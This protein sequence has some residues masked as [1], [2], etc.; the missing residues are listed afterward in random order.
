MTRDAL[1]KGRFVVLRLQSVLVGLLLLSS[2]VQAQDDLRVEI[3]SNESNARKRFEWFYSQRA[4]P[5][6]TVEQ[7]YLHRALEALQ[8]YPVERTTQLAWENIGPQPGTYFNYGNIGGRVPALAVHPTNSSIVYIGPADGGVWKTT[9]SGTTWTPLTDFLASLAS[10]SLAIDKNNP[11]TIYWGTGEPYYS[12]DAYGGAGVFRSTDGGASWTSAGLSAEKRIPRLAIDPNNS[13]RLFAATWG[14]IYRTTNS[15]GSWTKTLNLGYGYEVVIHPTNSSILY[16]GI[17]DNTS[18]AG[19]YKSTDN[20]V[21]WNKLT[22]GLPAS[23]NINRLKIEIAPSSPSTVYSLMSSRSPFG[24]MLGLYKTTDDGATWAQLTNAPTNLFGGGNQGWYDIMLG[25][26][27]TDPNLVFIGGLNIYRS[28]NGGTSWSNVSG[29]NVHVDQHSIGFGSGVA[30]AGNDGGIWKSTSNGTSWTN[31]NATFAVTQFYALG[32][33]KL[34]PSRVYGGTQDNGT[35]R[36]AGTLAWAGVLGGDGMMV[37]VDYTNSNIVYGES[38]NGHISRSINGGTSF[39]FL[40]DV[41]GAWVTP[42]RLH[43]TLPTTIFTANS[44][45]HRSTNSGTSWAEI[46]GD[47]NGTAKITW[48]TIHPETPTTI[49]ASSGGNIYR[50]TNDGTTWTVTT[51]GLPSRTVTQ[52]IVDPNSTATMYVTLSGT[53]TAHVYKS[54]NTGSSWS[55]INGNLPD[56]P[57][58]CLVVHPGNSNTLYVGTDLGVFITTNGGA[59]WLKET[60]MPNVAVIDMGI[61]SDDYLVAATH[62]RSMYRAPVDV[63]PTVTVNGPNGGESWAAGSV[64]AIQWSSFNVTG[65]VRIDLSRNGG[66]SFAETLFANTANDGSESWVVT[67]P[68]SSTVRIRISSVDQ[69]AV[70]D[71]SNTNFSIVQPVVMVTA[72]NGGENWVALS[73][74]TVQWTSSN[75][76]GNVKIEL[77]RNSGN[78]YE[79]LFAST[80]DDGSENWTPSMPATAEALVRVSSADIPSVG[81]TSN[82]VFT[83]ASPFYFFAYLTIRDNGNESSVLEFGT[84]AGATDGI[85][86]VYGEYELPPRPPVGAFDVRW[87]VA[88]TQGVLRDIRDT[89]D[90]GRSQVVYTGLLQAGAGGYPFTLEWNPGELPSGM[91][92]L[93]SGGSFYN[94]KQQDSLVITNEDFSTFQV[95]YSQSS[96]VSFNVLGGWNVLSVPVTVT[97]LRKVEVFPTAVSS[98]FA[99]TSGGYTMRDT[100]RYGEG[101]WLKYSTSQSID[102]T[103]GERNPDTVDVV[104]GWNM[105]GSI[106]HDVP[107]DSIISIPPGILQSSYFGFRPGAGYEVADTVK[108]MV[109][110]WVKVSQNGKLVLKRPADSLTRQNQSDPAAG[111]PGGPESSAVDPASAQ[112]GVQ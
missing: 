54:T 85:D 7:G 47:L 82:G 94:M 105:I 110:Y 26:H 103:G 42:L 44:R 39:S 20:G 91:F 60:G 40:Y 68:A 100:L 71:T 49:F 8:G 15:G 104:Q 31:C 43:P 86:P 96:T 22:S 45:V 95:I 41:A 93:K 69:P 58:N 89:I 70:A 109:G 76:T 50:T 112:K 17:G 14:G 63:A 33:D 62:G 37:Q 5:N 73:S 66:V 79:T 67:G 30:Y 18:N 12:I 56:V 24:G 3:G 2:L 16:A 35:Q 102:L 101:Y 98:A 29:T 87:S 55:S 27:P 97:D 92:Q 72:P 80:P 38:Q 48:L 75:L 74:Y 53:G 21:T 13:S 108:P 88:G 1:K 34:T 19:I 77:S 9:N 6:D 64:Q 83:I 57:T 84:A 36:T 78:N 52:I 65:N 32:L 59:T 28:T 46:S 106:S 61:T 23:S 25:V 51:S 99:Y 10:G 90:Q 111:Q 81:D 107:V 4:F 11:E